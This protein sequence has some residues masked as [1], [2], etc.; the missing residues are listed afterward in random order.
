MRCIL[1]GPSLALSLS[2]A[3]ALA[4]AQ[5][6]QAGAA[7]DILTEHL[8]AGTLEAGAAALEPLVSAEPADP[9]ALFALGALQ[10]LTAIETL[11]RDFHR[12]GLEA[13]S[14]LGMPLFRMPVPPNAAPEPL[15]YQALRDMLDRFVTGMDRAESTLAKVDGEVKIAVDLTKVRLD[16]D[17][18]GKAGD[19]EALPLLLAAADPTGLSLDEMGLPLEEGA[20]GEGG[21]VRLVFAFDRADAI[22]LRGYSQILASFADFL[23]AHDFSKLFDATFHQ[24]FPNAGL[25]MQGRSEAAASM[26][27]PDDT[28]AADALAFI[29]L[30]RFPVAEAE[31]MQRVRGRLLNIVGLSR[32]NWDA[33]LKETDDDREWLPAPR[34]TT[35]FPGLDVT[36][37]HVA[38]WLAFLDGAEAVLEGQLLVPHWRFSQGIDLKR[39][40]EEPGD[41]DL[42][43]WVTGQAA[44][45]YLAD[46]PVLAGDPAAAMGVFE[47]QLIGYALW[48]N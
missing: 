37:A 21:P 9:E 48:F 27:T 11:G 8:E 2:L 32:A 46:G 23:L 33:I 6:A 12:H 22:W 16:L 36:E 39:V 13:P 41:F 7:A 17:G 19:A 29:H 26:L 44:L 15:T 10:F 20:E 31:R 5:P 3:L 35:P 34:Q 45:P 43:L 40:F 1:P 30:I 18:D 25:P 24:L 28:R 47:G 42:V 38:A 14:A 4:L